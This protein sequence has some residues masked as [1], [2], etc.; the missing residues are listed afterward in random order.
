MASQR[1]TGMPLQDATTRHGR[2][3]PP[4]QTPGALRPVEEVRQ[5]HFL[6]VQRLEAHYCRE[7]EAVWAAHHQASFYRS[8]PPLPPEVAGCC[9][10]AGGGVGSFD[11]RG[12][13]G[14]GVGRAAQRSTAPHLNWVPQKSPFSIDMCDI[15]EGRPEPGTEPDWV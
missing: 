5:D 3:S 13:T 1:R 14:F 6:A 11:P 4:P 8:L 12:E 15:C 9:V 7:M 2:P 10:Q